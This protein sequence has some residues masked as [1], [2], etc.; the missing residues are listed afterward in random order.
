[1]YTNVSVAEILDT[2]GSMEANTVY[3]RRPVGQCGHMYE[4]FVVSWL[5]YND[6]S[7]TCESINTFVLGLILR[8][9][10]S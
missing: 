7:V 4:R 2:V 1:M 10:V 9:Y 6:P 5:P 8:V 3:V